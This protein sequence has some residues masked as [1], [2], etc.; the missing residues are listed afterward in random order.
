MKGNREEKDYDQ[1]GTPTP[2]DEY[3]P[4]EV[5]LLEDKGER[6]QRLQVHAL[7]QQ[8]EVVGQDTELEEGHC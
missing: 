3:V 5:F 4:P 8:P 6:Q 7:H 2:A 1:Q